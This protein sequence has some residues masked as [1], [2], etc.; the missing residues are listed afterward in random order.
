[1]IL[2]S[3]VIKITLHEEVDTEP[4]YTSILSQDSAYPQL[5]RK[6]MPK[7]YKVQSRLRYDMHRP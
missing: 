3:L 7:T 1:M 6:G 5:Y 4:K 2:K